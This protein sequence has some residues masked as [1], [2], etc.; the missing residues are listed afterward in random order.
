MVAPGG[1]SFSLFDAEPSH[2]FLIKTE[3]LHEFSPVVTLFWVGA[4]PHSD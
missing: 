2:L 4:N 3:M 1:L